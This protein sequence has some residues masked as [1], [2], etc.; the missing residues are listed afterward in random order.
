VERLNGF[1]IP[2]SD[3]V[4][5]V[6]DLVVADRL[7]VGAAGVQYPRL[8]PGPALP[9]VADPP[10]RFRSDERVVVGVVTT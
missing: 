6:F 1:R 3:V 10:L 9:P 7:V 2:G 5:G 8:E 4:L